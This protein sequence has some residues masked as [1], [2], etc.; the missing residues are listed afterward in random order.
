MR[1][2]SRCRTGRT[3]RIRDFRRP[4]VLLRRRRRA[5]A[6]NSIWLLQQCD[7]ARRRRALVAWQPGQFDTAGRVSP[8][9]RSSRYEVAFRCTLPRDGPANA[10]TPTRHAETSP[11]RLAIVSGSATTHFAG[12]IVRR[13]PP[14]SA[15][16]LAIRNGIRVLHPATAISIF[17]GA[18]LR[19][20]DHMTSDAGEILPRRSTSRPAPRRPPRPS[21]CFTG[22]HLLRPLPSFS[23]VCRSRPAGAPSARNLGPSRKGLAGEDINPRALQRHQLFL[24]APTFANRVILITSE[25]LA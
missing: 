7:A 24:V 8:G 12:R 11:A 14:V 18:R 13:V 10:L 17:F 15:R 2:D 1:R 5:H 3:R 19:R 25:Q 21:P 16:R 6:E 20:L 4:P 22:T 9:P 23:A